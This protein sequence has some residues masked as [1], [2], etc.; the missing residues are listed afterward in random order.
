MARRV[1]LALTGASLVVVAIVGIAFV[2]RPASSSR[3][4]AAARRS[5][6]TT[7]PATS[8][9]AE[10][11]P[12]M[13][14]AP[15][16]RPGGPLAGR[17]VAIDPGHNENDFR[18]PAEANRLVDAVTVRKPCDARGTATN[19]G[20]S[21][22]AFN[23]DVATRV[24]TKL[25]ALGARVVLTRD[26]STPWGPCITERAAIGN[27]ARADAAVSIHAD[28]GPSSGRGFHVIE[29]EKVGGPSDVI[30]TSSRELGSRLRDAYEAATGLPRST[31]AG[32]DGISVRRDLGGL[33]LST[34][35]K[36]FVE[37]GNLRNASDAA[38][39]TQPAFRDRVAQGI[40]DGLV[41]FL[42]R[43]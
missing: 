22:A 38:L 17:V 43:R 21:E 20:Y 9:T 8:S 37:C 34:V 18:H 27:R 35:P 29:P 12:P 3:A 2:R 11:G 26:R 40:T 5:A 33:N 42:T 28:G 23:F 31:Y 25:G 39:L 36:V 14:T 4:E 10:A 16:D 1:V 7:V 13:S 24:A 15:P 19:D 32:T 6:P 41:G 30:I